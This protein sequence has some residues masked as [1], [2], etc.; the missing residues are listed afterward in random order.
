MEKQAEELLEQ[1]D[2]VGED[3]EL[4]LWVD[5]LEFVANGV[6]SRLAA[7]REDLERQ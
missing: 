6:D 1:L 4:D 7:A 2:T 3:I 5:L